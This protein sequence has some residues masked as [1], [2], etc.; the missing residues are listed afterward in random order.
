MPDNKVKLSAQ[1]LKEA[2]WDTLQDVKGD[3]MNAP[4][5]DS[6]AS[7]ARE[8]L[9]TTQTQLRIAQQAKRPVSAEVI[10]FAEDK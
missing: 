6:I 5:A 3:R 1:S 8:I 10:A 2:L 7:A 4:R 9:R